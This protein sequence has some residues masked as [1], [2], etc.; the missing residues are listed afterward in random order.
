MDGGD[1]ICGEKELEFLKE[2]DARLKEVI[3]RVGVIK[4]RAMPDLFEALVRSITAQ[5]IS[6]KAHETLWNRM[7]NGI[8]GISAEKIDA[9]EIEKL[10]S[11]GMSFK[12]AGYIKN[13]AAKIVSGEFDI[14]A[15]RNMDDEK[16]VETLTSLDGIGVWSAEMLMIFSMR[17]PNVLSFGDFAI[18]RGLRMIYRHRRI[19]RALFE[20]YHRRFSP[21]CSAASLYIWEISSGK[22][23]GYRD[24]APKSGKK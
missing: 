6:S 3:S 20:K 13:A 21:Y 17:R 2:R 4:R 22:Y 14:S 16:V 23:E 15:L 9:L 8:G 5:Q 19:T 12:K 1:F 11:F 7:L 18:Q 10:Q 24:L